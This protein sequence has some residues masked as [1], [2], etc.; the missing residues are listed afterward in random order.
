MMSNGYAVA[1]F[2]IALENNNLDYCQES[3]NAFMEMYISLKD[4]QS[5][6]LSPNVS[7]SDKKNIV[8]K[9]F[10]GCY[11]DFIYFLNVLIDNQQ[12]NSIE[13]IYRDFM[14]LFNEKKKIKIV[15]VISNQK[16]DEKEEDFLI[17]A[18]SSYFKNYKIVLNN[19]IDESKIAGYSLF[20]DGKNIDLS[21]KRQMNSL[22]LHL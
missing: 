1:L 21:A 8:E 6:M 7:A 17:S 19:V 2:E 11:Q 5:V 4:F 10:Q 15:K 22:K 9:S 14:T 16:L 20:C 3:F 18:L 13:E 12:L